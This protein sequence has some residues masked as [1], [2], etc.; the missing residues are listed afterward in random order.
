MAIPIRHASPENVAAGARTFF[1]TSSIAG[2]RNLLQ[3]D[4][5]AQLFVRVVCEY[6]AQGKF[7][8]HELVVM[9]DH[10]HL[11]LTVDSGMTV[12]RAVQFIKGGF[13][14]RA[15]R[16]CGMRPPIWQKGFYDVRIWSSQ[17]YDG[18]REYIHNN[19]VKRRLVSEAGLYPYSSAHSGF[20]LD[21]VP[22][23]LKPI[24]FQD[25]TGTAEAM[26]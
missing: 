7:R 25:M 9:P 10:F 2:K 26:P 17:Q 20:E 5:S 16:E 18:T 13:A 12:E 14:F 15:G 3:S 24:S 23:G 1:I 8:L 4:R 22:Q 6:R 11:L 21:A 19:P